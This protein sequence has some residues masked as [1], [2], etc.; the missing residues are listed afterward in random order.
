MARKKLSSL[1][2]I[3]LVSVLASGLPEDVEA[4]GD[5]HLS[6]AHQHGHPSPT[7]PDSVTRDPEQPAS[8][9]AHQAAPQTQPPVSHHAH[10]AAPAAPQSHA[11]HHDHALEARAGDAESEP[12]VLSPAEEAFINLKTF[13]LQPRSVREP[14]RFQARIRANENRIHPLVAGA[15]G[16]ITAVGDFVPGIEVP[17]QGLLG[18]FSSTE[19]QGPVQAYLVTLDTIDKQGAVVTPGTV[20]PEVA[21]QQ[22]N[23]YA[24]NERLAADR[25]YTLGMSIAQ[26][27]EIARTRRI[28]VEFEIRAP[29]RALL[30]GYNLYPGQRFS[31]GH[32]WARLVETDQVWAEVPVQAMDLWHF[33]AGAKVRIEI[34]GAKHRLDGRVSPALPV[35]DAAGTALRV[36][37]EI[38]NRNLALRPG[39]QVIGTLVGDS[40]KALL[41]PLDALQMGETGGTARVFVA[42]GEGR[43]VL[44]RVR[45]GR[46]FGEW[47]EILEGLKP[48]EKLVREGA[49]LLDAE[50]RMKS[51]PAAHAHH[52]S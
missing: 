42:L 11:P 8:P 49:F 5:P 29:R 15:S 3:A 26:V 37:I 9:H 33:K 20:S 23:Y 35:P 50:Q 1:A 25:L 6:A 52:H 39:M 13:R 41:A 24:V 36:R 34:P 31:K 28:P 21:E 47:V 12:L 2:H 18:K 30:E 27:R 44:K 40:P 10:P 14:I 17:A 38:K 7:A 4:A 45:V 48:G 51:Q 32:E 43:F 22:K 46:S 19:L 16:F